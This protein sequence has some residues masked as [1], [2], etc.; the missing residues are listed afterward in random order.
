VFDELILSA[1]RTGGVRT[2]VNLAAGL[3]TRPYRLALPPDLRWVEVDLPG[4]IAYKNEALRGEQPACAVERVALDLAARG[5]RQAFLTGAFPTGPAARASRVLVVTEG[6]L[7]YET[8]V[9]SLADDLR[10]A[11]PT[12]FFR[13]H[14]WAPRETRSLLDE[15]ERLKRELPAV[16]L[17]RR[18]SPLL[19]V[20]GRAYARRH[21]RFRDAML[22]A[23]MDAIAAPS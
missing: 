2:V 3:D 18:V 7:V 20:L 23:V 5:E 4:I 10:R 12:E 13:P 1:V 19:P 11:L 8:E 15:A 17:L 14:G 21:A 22:Y 6:L 16:A 9:G